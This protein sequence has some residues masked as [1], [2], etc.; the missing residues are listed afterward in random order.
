MPSSNSGCVAAGPKRATT[1]SAL[2]MIA[3]LPAGGGRGLRRPV[4]AESAFD[5]SPRARTRRVAAAASPR[6]GVATC[7][8]SAA[9]RPPPSPAPPRRNEPPARRAAVANVPN[10]PARAPFEQRAV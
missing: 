10:T 3:L 6:R 4:S 8:P 7:A 2:W 1:P 5:A 9:D